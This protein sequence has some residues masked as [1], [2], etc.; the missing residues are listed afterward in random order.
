MSDNFH[1]S[2][3]KSYTKYL[4]TKYW[5][6]IW[7]NYGLKSMTEFGSITNTGGVKEIQLLLLNK[8]GRFC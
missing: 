1:K 2:S 6:K 7:V 8:L 3:C 4:I 5:K